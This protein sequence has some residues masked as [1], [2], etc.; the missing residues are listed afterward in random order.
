MVE[1]REGKKL[2]LVLTFKGTHFQ[3]VCNNLILKYV[4]DD[5]VLSLNVRTA[6]LVSVDEAWGPA[7]IELSL[8]DLI[9]RK[10]VSISDLTVCLDRRGALGKIEVYQDPLLY[11]CSLEVRA[12]WCYQSL[13]SMIPFKTLMNVSADKMEFS[14]TGTQVAELS[15]LYIK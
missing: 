3:I 9:L 2:L 11:R 15:V 10:L 8:P 7:F 4:E 5:M 6:S 1:P 12:A 14:T 13:N